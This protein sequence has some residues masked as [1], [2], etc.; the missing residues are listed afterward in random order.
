[1]KLVVPA[2][3]AVLAVLGILAGTTATLIP[4]PTSHRDLDV[5]LEGSR[6]ADNQCVAIVLDGTTREGAVGEFGL[7]LGG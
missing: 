5:T 2:A 1:M 7:A 6:K 4:P 3:L